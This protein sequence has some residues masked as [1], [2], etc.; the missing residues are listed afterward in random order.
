MDN[1]PKQGGETQSGSRK[2]WRSRLL[3]LVILG[4]LSFMYFR[5]I[6]FKDPKTVNVTALDLRDL[7]DKLI[8]PDKL[9]DRAVILNYWAPWCG[10]CQIETPWLAKIQQEHG[11][12]LTVIGVLADDDS[13]ADAK[14][15]MASNGVNYP[16][17]RMNTSLHGAIGSV[18]SLPTTF[19]ISPSGKVVH[20]VSGMIAQSMMERYAT[21]AIESK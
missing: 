15:F 21:A 7:N 20:T 18:D 5:S 11:N 6:R 4:F 13:L 8:S 14:M 10:P 16:V 1:S 17:A 12:S 3:F 9:R 2:G 19:Y